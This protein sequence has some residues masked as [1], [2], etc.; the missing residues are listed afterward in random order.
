MEPSVWTRSV[1]FVRDGQAVNQLV[2]NAP[3]QVLADRTTALKAILDS[4]VAGE[5][6]IVRDAPLGDGV[7]EGHVVYL[8]P[9]TLRYELAL[10]RYQDLQSSSGRLT[11]ADSAVFAGVV[12]TKSTAYAGD[13]LFNG[14]GQ[15]SAAAVNRLFNGATPAPKVYYLSSLYAGSVELTPPA[16]MVRACQY[17]DSDVVRVFAPTFEPETHS[18]RGYRLYVGDWRAVGTFDPDLVPAGAVYGY[19][20]DSPQALAEM[21]RESLLPAM[22]EPE[23]VWDYDSETGSSD[24]PGDQT[25]A[26]KHVNDDSIVLTETGIWWLSAVVPPQDIL[27]TITVADA[28]QMSILYSIWSKTP[29]S[30]GV[31]NTNGR[32]ALE[33]KALTRVN[34]WTEDYVVGDVDLVT[35]KAHRRK[36][37]TKLTGGQF[38][39]VTPAEGVGEVV[40][41]LAMYSDT[42]VDAEIVNLNN[43]ITR[44]EAPLV[45]V[46]FPENRT[47]SAN[48]KV[49]LPN[50]TPDTLYELTLWGLFLGVGVTLDAPTVLCSLLPTPT[51]SGVAVVPAA[52]FPVMLG[53]IPAGT[54]VY[55]VEC[56]VIVPAD[57][58]ANGAMFYEFDVDMPAAPV[59]LLGTGVRISL[60]AV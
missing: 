51:I 6:L 50:L 58:L 53:T 4:I 7:E 18:H 33:L 43:S 59:K 60:K 37:V 36:V 19:Y 38:L 20:M 21:L 31:T 10:A 42:N 44:T 46:E 40:V 22:G 14:L 12:M 1:P 55:L 34:D 39:K 52:G 56:S 16:M 29:A 13:I 15:L 17:I 3:T 8:N 23:Y 47:S 25:L 9:A 24:T 48:F 49:P 11:P 2:T 27:M 54:A 28:R 35:G 45:F 26:G 5:Q 57:G 32:V 30:L 41:D